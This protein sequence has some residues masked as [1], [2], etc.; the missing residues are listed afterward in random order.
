RHRRP[1]GSGTTRRLI[2]RAQLRTWGLGH[3]DVLGLCAR[4]CADSF[5]ERTANQAR[6]PGRSAPGAAERP[7]HCIVISLTRGSQSPL[8]LGR[9]SGGYVSA[10]H[11]AIAQLVSPGG[12]FT[13]AFRVSFIRAIKLTLTTAGLQCQCC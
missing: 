7:T 11:R 4:G 9:K 10:R 6:R 8:A 5:E 12:K 2:D 1:T 3:Y 13:P